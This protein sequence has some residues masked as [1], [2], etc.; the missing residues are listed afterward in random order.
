MKLFIRI[1]ALLLLT[2]ALGLSACGDSP[3]PAGPETL[4][5]PPQPPT[6]KTPVRINV[7]ASRTGLAD[8]M[9]EYPGLT[10]DSDMS[11]GQGFYTWNV[12][13]AQLPRHLGVEVTGLN[14]TEKYRPEADTIY[15]FV[16]G[17]E[18]SR[19]SGAGFWKHPDSTAN[20]TLFFTVYRT[21]ETSRDLQYG[22]V[23]YH[24]RNGYFSATANRFPWC[25]LPASFR[26]PN[27]QTGKPH[28]SGTGW[29]PRMMETG[30]TFRGTGPNGTITFGSGPLTEILPEAGSAFS[31]TGLNGG[32]F[33]TTVR[34]N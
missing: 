34:P 29:A 11:I 28:Y 3:N 21:G 14:G 18:N 27:V 19:I 22:P 6:G 12:E 33:L 32:N 5:D 15:V 20:T 25:H 13:L 16:P 1:S 2:L 7:F 8:R 9:G 4:P 24:G 23:L 26:I 31:T 17:T 10:V 30:R